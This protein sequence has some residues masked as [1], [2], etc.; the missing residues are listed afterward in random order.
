VGDDLGGK[1][2]IPHSFENSDFD[3][4]TLSDRIRK[5]DGYGDLGQGYSK[6]GKGEDSHQI[7][8]MDNTAISESIKQYHCNKEDLETS[9][10]ALLDQNK[11]VSAPS[12]QVVIPAP[13]EVEISEDAIVNTQ[14]SVIS[15]KDTVEQDGQLKN[16]SQNED[17]AKPKMKMQGEIRRSERLKNDITVTT[18]E[19]NE[20]MAKKRNLEG[21]PLATN[22]F[23]DLPVESIKCLSADMGIAVNN[24]NFGTF[25]MLKD[26]E[27]ARHNLHIKHTKPVVNEQDEEVLEDNDL[28][29]RLIE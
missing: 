14:E 20:R 29:E 10:P 21:N 27:I 19:K 28:H 16:L 22:M 17:D 5:I 26:L 8:C 9:I 6:Q 11:D 23:S 18:K 25:N 7:W 4:E 24:I 15:G 2:H 12:Q 3:S 13:T 1:V